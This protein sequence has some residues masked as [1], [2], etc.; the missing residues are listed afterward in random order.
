MVSGMASWSA[1]AQQAP[2]LAEDA[3]GLFYQFGVGLGFLAT[4]RPDGG[5][6]LHPIC[7]IVTDAGLYALLVPSP[8]RRDLER[9]GRFALH[10]FSPADIDDECYLTGTAHPITDTKVWETV[11][12]A[13]HH[14][15]S[16]DETLFELDIDRCMIARY[17]HRGDWPPKYNVWIDKPLST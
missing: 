7:P 13:Y 11:S 6:R 5:P 12:D 14:D 3:K 16:Q 4:V 8:K 9:D 10:A 1:F 17:K 2:E 15:P